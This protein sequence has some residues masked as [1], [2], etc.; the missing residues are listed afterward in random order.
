M[1]QTYAIENKQNATVN[2]VES[3]IF[4]AYRRIGD[5]WYYI[6]QYKVPGFDATDTACEQAL[7]LL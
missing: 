3:T 5:A 1:T 2:D 7:R 6:G 4:V